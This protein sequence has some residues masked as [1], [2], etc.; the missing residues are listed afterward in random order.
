MNKR[1]PESRETLLEVL[2]QAP[3]RP[4]KR[5]PVFLDDASGLGEPLIV[6]A[7]CEGFADELA[8]HRSSH[9]RQLVDDVA[10]L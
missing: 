2:L 8:E 4:R 9:M 7:G 10:H 6:C 1:E 5:I 3:H